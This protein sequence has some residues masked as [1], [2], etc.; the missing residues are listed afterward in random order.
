MRHTRSRRSS[1]WIEAPDPVAELLPLACFVMSSWSAQ[2]HERAAVRR[3]V[4]GPDLEKSIHCVEAVRDGRSGEVLVRNVADRVLTVLVDDNPVGIHEPRL[5]VKMKG[6]T[7]V[8]LVVDQFVRILRQAPRLV[9]VPPVPALPELEFA[10]PRQPTPGQ[11]ARDRDL[12]TG[13][14]DQIC[15]MRTCDIRS[16]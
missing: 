12:S 15:D 2:T 8:A 11:I 9:A 16:G 3:N 6:H 14:V 10:A 5:V 13:A 4:L 1:S 7:D